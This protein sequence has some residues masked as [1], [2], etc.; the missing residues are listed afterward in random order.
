MNMQ[1]G[2]NVLTNH[3]GH[4]SVELGESLSA[5]NPKMKTRNQKREKLYKTISTVIQTNSIGAIRLNVCS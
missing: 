5:K 4:L 3:F 2:L 1:I